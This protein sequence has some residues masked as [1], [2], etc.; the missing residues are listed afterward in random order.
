MKFPVDCSCGNLW[1]TE[2]YLDYQ[3]ICGLDGRACGCVVLSKDRDSY[4]VD[5][6]D[7]CKKHKENV[8]NEQIK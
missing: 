2:T 6:P 4:I 7:K 5:E 3:T 8:E 1:L